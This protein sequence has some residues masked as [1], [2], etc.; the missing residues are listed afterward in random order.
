MALLA[1][2]PK[3]IDKRLKL[4]MFGPPGVGKTTA[5]I[6]FPK[7]YILDTERGAENDQYVDAINKSDGAILS[8]T[9]FDT[10]VD[11]V[12]ALASE[13][14]EFR[15]L[16]IDPITVIYDDLVAYWEKRVGTD[17]GRGYSAAKKQWKRL[18]A[19]I[20]TLD[21]NV[22]MTSH[23]KNLYAEGTAMKIIG[24]TYDGPKGADYYMDLVLE[25][26]KDGDDRSCR[27]AKSRIASLP[28]GEVI[29]FGYDEIAERYGRDTLE[30]DATVI[31]F[32]SV[33]TV[34]AVREHLAQ[35]MD[36][37]ELEG[38]WL[39]AAGVADLADMTS[40]Q[41]EGCA[42]WLKAQ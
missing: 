5:A 23:A 33:E 14:H 7:P 4:M 41:M 39:R 12:R 37:E 20:S 31:E 3:K 16:V 13:P 11:Q 40:E 26:I 29:P 8:T 2:K 25:A 32:A 9:S 10:I 6:Q 1:K 36:G 19:L 42:Q 27:I 22:V 38:K 24:M 34:R 28:E 17:F 15:T 30:R 18:T 21:M 35:R